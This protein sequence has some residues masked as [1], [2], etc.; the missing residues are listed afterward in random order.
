MWR[1]IACP[2][3]LFA[4]L[5]SRSG[6][7]WDWAGPCLPSS[8]GTG[9]RGQL[10]SLPLASSQFLECPRRGQAACLW[11]GDW[12]RGIAACLGAA[13]F[14]CHVA[15]LPGESCAMMPAPWYLH[16]GGSSP[17]PHCPDLLRSCS[18]R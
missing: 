1:A 2:P 8:L 13:L 15:W 7:G 18:V 10:T 14:S 5:A 12:G 9:F 3:W 11:V 17:W 4:L 6:V 16:S